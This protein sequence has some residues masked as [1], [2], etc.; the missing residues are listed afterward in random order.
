[1]ASSLTNISQFIGG[2]FERV[3]YALSSSGL[4]FD[5]TSPPAQTEGA[6]LTTLEGAN[7]S[8]PTL[9]GAQILQIEGDNGVRGV[10]QFPSNQQPT[11]DL[12][13]ADFTGTFLNAIIPLNL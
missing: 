11:F 8:N 12:T 4:P 5:S 6:G 10:I 9:G 1:M 7:A 13:F 2:G 3:Q